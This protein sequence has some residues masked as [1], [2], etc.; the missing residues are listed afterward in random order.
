MMSPYPGRAVVRTVNSITTNN[1]GCGSTRRGG[2]KLLLTT[3]ES[4]C[5]LIPDPE[6][7]PWAVATVYQPEKKKEFIV[8]ILL[9]ILFSFLIL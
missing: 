4:A 9:F 7:V 1:M 2:Y 8:I 5:C 3:L 6:A